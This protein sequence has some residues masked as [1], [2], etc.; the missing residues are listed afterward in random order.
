MGWKLSF[1]GYRVSVWGGEKVLE[2]DSSES[3]TM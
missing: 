2:V 1:N 3:T